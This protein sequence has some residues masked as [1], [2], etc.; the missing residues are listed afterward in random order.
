MRKS[1]HLK[2]ALITAIDS[3][4]AS[5]PSSS[6]KQFLLFALDKKHS[7][8]VNGTATHQPA[9]SDALPEA[10]V[11]LA[12][13]AQ[14]SIHPPPCLAWAQAETLSGLPLR[15]PQVL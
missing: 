9:E 7:S 12:V 1:P 13:L 5:S 6:S 3:L 4:Y 8:Q 14:V 10:F 2:E 15:Q 11:Y